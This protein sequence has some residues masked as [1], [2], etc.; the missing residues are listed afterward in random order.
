M[1]LTSKLFSKYSTKK[2]RG[3]ERVG[4]ILAVV[5]VPQDWL[6]AASE[7]GDDIGLLANRKFTVHTRST[8]SHA[9]KGVLMMISRDS[10]PP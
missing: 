8:L 6:E 9:I 1:P 2:T 10:F 4:L 3:R 5:V 7:R